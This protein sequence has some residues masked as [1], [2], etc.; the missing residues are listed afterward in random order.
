ME[1]CLGFGLVDGGG[2]V[3]DFGFWMR[4][5]LGP[6]VEGVRRAASA[7]CRN[8]RARLSWLGIW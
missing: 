5:G 3:S 6:V 1:A 2:V 8:L 4:M 7:I